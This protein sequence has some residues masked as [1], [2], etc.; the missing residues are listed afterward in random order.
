MNQQ[1]MNDQFHV[2]VRDNC[3]DVAREFIAHGAD[4]NHNNGDPIYTATILDNHHEMLKMLIDAGAD[5]NI[6]GHRP[7]KS[8][9][10]KGDEKAL[11]MLFEPKGSFNKFHNDFPNALRLATDSQEVDSISFGVV[12]TLLDKGYDPHYMDDMPVKQATIDNRADVVDVLLEHGAN[13]NASGDYAIRQAA[14]K[15]YNQVLEIA[16]VKHGVK[17]TQESVEWMKTYNCFDRVEHLLSKRALNERLT[18]RMN[19]RPKQ[20]VKPKGLSLKI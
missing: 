20:K 18:Q 16:I 7:I 1:Q 14:I 13:F 4:I 15:D 11:E 9:I 5:T 19:E 10:Y 6:K 3:L 12:K 8:A 2:A 17:P